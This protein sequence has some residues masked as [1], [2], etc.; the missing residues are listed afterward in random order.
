[1]GYGDDV[2]HNKEYD[3]GRREVRERFLPNPRAPLRQQ[4]HEVMRFRRY[5]PRTEEAYWHWIERFLRHHRRRD[6]TGPESWRHPREMGTVEVRDFLTHLAVALNVSASTQNQALNALVFLYGEVLDRPLGDFAD[7]A[8]AVRPPRLPVVLTREEVR[9]VLAATEAGFALPL[10]LLY[11]TGLRLFELL[12]LRVKDLDLARRLIVVR[13]GEGAKDRVTM[14]PESLVGE[15]GDQIARVKALHE[16]DLA[17]GYVGV[18]LPDA[19]A[20]KYPSAARELAWQWVFPGASLTEVRNASGAIE[21]W[22]H[23]LLPETLQRAMK[24]AVRRTGVTKAA[25]P[26]TLRHAFATHQLEA[27]TDI[28]THGPSS[29]LIP[30]G[31]IAAAHTVPASAASTDRCSTTGDPGGGGGSALI[32]SRRTPRRRCRRTGRRALRPRCG[33]RPPRPAAGTRTPPACGG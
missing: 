22:R 2:S 9:A 4:V 13:D 18:W 25:T 15:L 3:D 17:A 8:R 16:A 23:H 6:A 29:W 11:G 12:R 10:R 21:Q 24:A 20:R 27:G 31:L 30:S 28:R 1:M 5:S 33:S 19:L 14:V 26:H 7:F 32:A